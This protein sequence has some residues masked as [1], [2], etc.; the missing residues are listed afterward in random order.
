M[1]G[2]LDCLGSSRATHWAKLPQTM[3]LVDQIAE[4]QS[5][6]QNDM[7]GLESSEVNDDLA[8]SVPDWSPRKALENETQAL[9]LY[10]P[11]HP[12]DHA[13]DQ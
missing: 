6:G 3:E 13:H 10:L 1:S 7:F 5:S 12:V 4:D 9:G 11:G 2:S 8:I